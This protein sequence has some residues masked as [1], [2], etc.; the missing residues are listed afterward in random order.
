MQSKGINII[1]ETT[2]N[3]VI[4]ALEETFSTGYLKELP[5][6]GNV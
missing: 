5:K 2:Q 4:K 1:Q 6:E 3:T